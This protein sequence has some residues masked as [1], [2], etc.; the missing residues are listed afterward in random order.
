[1]HHF[2][3]KLP[4]QK[5]SNVKT[6]WMRST[7]WTCHK[8]RSFASNYLI[9]L[10]FFFFFSLRTSY[11]ELI[12][13][14]NTSNIYIHTLPKRWSLISGCFFPARILETKTNSNFSVKKLEGATAHFLPVWW[15]TLLK[16]LYSLICENGMH[17]T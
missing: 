12:W 5:R 11:K 4:C 17:R 13:C 8:W 9:F 10:I 7:K 15:I 1:M 16:H 6:N 14:T 2:H 3:T